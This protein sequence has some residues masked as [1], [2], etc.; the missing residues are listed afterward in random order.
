MLN[1]HLSFRDVSGILAASVLLLGTLGCAQK[2]EMGTAMRGSA[3]GA[4]EIPFTT[5][6]EAARALCEEGEYLS[7]VGRNVQAREKFIAAVAEDPTFVRAHF[8][9]A[10]VANSYKE[11]QGCID[12]A[13][14]NIESVSEGEQLM[15]EINRTLLTNDTEQGVRL[16]IELV[17][18]RVTARH[19]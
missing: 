4:G 3:P 1:R 5:D 18:L 16:A 6:S 7:D 10:N 8:D 17:H 12:R 19:A 14:V 2:E 9:Q 11:F 15:V 13:E